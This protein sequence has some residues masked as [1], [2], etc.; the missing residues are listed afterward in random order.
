MPANK[1]RKQVH[2]RL[3]EEQMDRLDWLKSLLTRES[4]QPVSRNNV[5]VQLVNDEYC[6]RNGR[7]KPPL[8]KTKAK[9]A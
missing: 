7:S 6:R 8:R 1:E 9:L 2:V 5:I 3:Y 4:G